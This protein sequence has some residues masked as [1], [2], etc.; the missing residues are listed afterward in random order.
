MLNKYTFIVPTNAG[1]VMRNNFLA[2]PLFESH[3]TAEIIIQEN[4]ASAA[5]AYNNAIDKA[6]TEILIFIHQDI[7]LPEKWLDNLDASLEY[8]QERD[9]EWGVL[10]CHGETKDGSGR[11]YLYCTGNG[12]YILKPFDRPELVQT[13]DEIVLIIRKSSRL[14]F[15]E[16]LPHFHLYGTD[17]CMTAYEKGMNCYAIPA[18]C[19]HNS[20]ETAIYP[21][22]FFICC[23][24]IM[25]KW[26]R[27][28]PIYTSCVEI[29]EGNF[30]FLIREKY[31]RA[32]KY[33]LSKITNRNRHKRIRLDKPVEFMKTLNIVK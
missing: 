30:I 32:L 24:Y 15:D 6:K 19:L 3:Q 2:S 5:K 22:E 18:F 16:T 7:V 27:H 13:L 14:R 4:Y 1:D 10:G 8:L 20:N 25:K 11:G 33:F 21:S 28:L 26:R 9:P 29:I 17:I 23:Y 31:L 12:R